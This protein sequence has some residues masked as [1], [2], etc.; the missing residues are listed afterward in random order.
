MLIES[1]LTRRYQYVSYTNCKSERLEIKTGI[2]QGSI[3][4]QLFFNNYINN[5]VN[6]TDIV[7]FLMYTDDTPLYFSIEDLKTQSRETA[8]NTE[9]NKVNTWL[10]LNKL[11]V[12]V[13]KN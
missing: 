1:Y 5:I 12:N 3:L 11:S 6:S 10:R 7:Y 8:T 9:I 2:P 4:D 13:E